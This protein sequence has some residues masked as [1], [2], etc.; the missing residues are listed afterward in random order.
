MNAIVRELPLRRQRTI[1]SLMEYRHQGL[2]E[3]MQEKM[4]LAESEAQ[5]L[6]RETKRF[7]FL[8]SISNERLAPSTQIDECWHN[9]ILFTKDY[10][11]F[12]TT[13]FGT[14]I[15]HAPKTR[16]ERAV[17]D[18]SI[19]RRTTALARQIFGDEIF[20]MNWSY[21][22]SGVNDFGDCSGS[23][24]CQASTSDPPDK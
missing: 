21:G 1:D 7:L 2:I 20:T 6:F 23:T 3:R 11:R 10:A 19:K 5:D 9:F 14:F 12:C 22:P 4:S 18:G 16:A 17:S 8:C 24:N 15:H 13:F